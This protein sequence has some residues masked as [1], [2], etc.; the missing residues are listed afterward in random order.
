MVIRSNLNVKW[1]RGFILKKD[2]RLNN[3]IGVKYHIKTAWPDD[4]IAL[5]NFENGYC[6][7]SK[8]EDGKYCLCYLTTAKNLKRS[9]NSV[10]VLEKNF[11]HENSHLRQI[12]LNAEKIMTSPLT[13]A[14]ISFDGKRQVEN[15]V[16]MTGDAAGM[17]TPLCGNGMSMALHGSKMTF[18]LI[19]QFLQKKISRHQMED[20]YSREWKEMFSRRL[21]TGKFIQKLFGKKW[22]TNFFITC[23]KP[24]P[25]FVKYLIRQTHGQPF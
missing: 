18:Q 25:G 7:I 3:Y 13:I 23:V 1:K 9:G 16:L 10:E 15:H 24:F 11:L 21:R 8:V 12:F 22:M 20:F 17:I 4:L 19:N 14:Q 6:G 2:N 5:H